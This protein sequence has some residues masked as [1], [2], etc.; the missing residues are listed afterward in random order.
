ME[1]FTKIKIEISESG[2]DTLDSLGPSSTVY[3]TD[4]SDCS[5][6]AWFTLFE[7]V[8][9]AA[10]FDEPVI[11]AGGCQLAFNE[12]RSPGVMRKVAHQY[13]IKLLEDTPTDDDDSRP[14]LQQHQQDE[15]S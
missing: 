12:Y 7:R 14:Q 11:A 8:L 13:D 6:H 2:G 3:E 5:V 4:M 10:G 1:Y 9:R 15:Q